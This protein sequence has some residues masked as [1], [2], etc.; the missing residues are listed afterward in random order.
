CVYVVQLHRI[1]VPVPLL[2]SVYGCAYR[3]LLS[4]PTRRSSDLAAHVLWHYRQIG[5]PPGGF[6]SRLIAA[7]AGADPGNRRLLSRGFPEYGRAM[8][9]IMDDIDGVERLRRVMET[10]RPA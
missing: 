10:R 4:C 3:T 9:I 1:L 6:V 5:Y 8:S 2:T 7:F